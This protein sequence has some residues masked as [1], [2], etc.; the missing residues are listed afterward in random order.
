MYK[1]INKYIKATKINILL[2]ASNKTNV[3]QGWSS[4]KLVTI[5]LA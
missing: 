3:D 1:G 4:I 5:V 2:H